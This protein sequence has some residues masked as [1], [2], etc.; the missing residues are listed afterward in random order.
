MTDK[1]TLLTYDTFW[2]KASPTMTADNNLDL[3]LGS[4]THLP[5]KYW[6]RNFFFKG[7]LNSTFKTMTQGQ[8][9]V[10]ADP[11]GTHPVFAL[12]PVAHG[13]GFKVCPC[14]SS[15]WKKLKW[16]KKGTQLLHTERIMEKTSYLVEHI[17]FNMPVSESIKLRFMGEVNDHDIHSIK[18]GVDHGNG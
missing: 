3:I 10:K 1:K 7:G 12:K 8:F 5:L 15:A 16:I 2:D 13:A 17:Q 14:S 9:P 11:K 6:R 4:V 18:K